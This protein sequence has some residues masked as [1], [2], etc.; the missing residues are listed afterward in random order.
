[1]PGD[2]QG[3]TTTQQQFWSLQIF[4]W[5]GYFIIVFLAIIRPQFDFADFDLTG[6]L[7]HLC[8]ETLS[9]FALS[10]VQWAFIRRVI[11]KPLNLALVLSF[12]SAAALGIVLNVIKLASY[13]AIIYQQVWYEHLSML[14]FGGWLLFSIATLFVFTAIFFIMLYNNR[15]QTEHQM[16]LRTQTLAKES[17][18]QMLRYQL[19]PHFMFNTLN[20]ISTLI[21]KRE[22]DDANEMLDKLCEFFRYS[23]ENTGSETCTLSDDIKLVRLYLSIE[24]VRFSNRLNVDFDISTSAQSALLPNMLLQPIVENAI[25]YGIES[26]KKGGVISIRADVLSDTLVISVINTRHDNAVDLPKGFGIGLQNTRERLDTFFGGR[27]S[28]ELLEH[29]EMAEVKLSMPF[30]HVR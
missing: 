19:N 25:K 28:V 11:H 24:E 20:A 16:L 23:L 12:V 30:K 13:K 17:Q 1:M 8:V 21:L 22:N 6:Q 29:E 5:V 9:G 2:I 14:E 4:G 3:F 10:C 7:I 15:L 26:C 27:T 18:L